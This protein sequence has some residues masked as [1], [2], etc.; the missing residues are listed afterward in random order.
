MRTSCMTKRFGS[1]R[2]NDQTPFESSRTSIRSRKV[3]TP[4]RPDPA[5]FG[6]AADFGPPLVN[7]SHVPGV[8]R[9]H[10]AGD[11]GPPHRTGRDGSSKIPT[12]TW[13]A[14]KRSD[15]ARH[16]PRWLRFSSTVQS[17]ETGSHVN[18]GIDILLCCLLG[19]ILRIHDGAGEQR[20]CFLQS[21]AQRAKGRIEHPLGSNSQR[22]V[23]HIRS[24]CL[25]SAADVTS[26]CGVQLQRRSKYAVGRPQRVEQS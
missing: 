18:A 20:C 16:L 10:R 6:A 9:S 1:P 17:F 19:H 8:G 5:N 24:L 26:D 15:P 25:G 4:A 2:Q 12:E 11:V 22:R 14:S 3:E 7:M 13:H 21:R 23:D